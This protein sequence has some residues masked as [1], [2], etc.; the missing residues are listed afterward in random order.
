MDNDLLREEVTSKSRDY[1]ADDL[2]ID[3]DM[4]MN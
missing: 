2:D 3:I 4:T 1:A